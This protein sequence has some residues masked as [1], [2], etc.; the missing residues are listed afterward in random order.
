M[1]GGR[2]EGKDKNRPGDSAGERDHPG[3]G[4]LG[5]ERYV[6]QRPS[7]SR[8]KTFFD[9]PRARVASR[10]RARQRDLRSRRPNA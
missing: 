10:E 1:K 5:G 2:E 4:T 6:A 7:L 8:A 9:V 3:S